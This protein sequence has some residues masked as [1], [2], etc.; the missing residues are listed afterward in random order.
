MTNDALN[1]SGLDRE[2]VLEVARVTEA[3]ALAAARFRGLGNERAADEA[4]VE[5]MHRELARLAIVGQVVLGE[6]SEDEAEKLYI[7]EAIGAGGGP[8]VDIAADPLEGSTLCAKG[9][10]NALSVIAVAERGRLLRVPSMYMSKV[11][12]GPGYP[13]GLVDLDATPA[14]NLARL[15]EAK[16]VAVGELTAC[17]LDR[18]RN[19]ELIRQVREAGAAI[20]LIPD[21]DI[22]GVI[23]TTEPDETGIDI[24]LGIG[25]APE[26]VL[27]AAALSCIGGQIQGRLAPISE[28]DRRRARR[29]GID[30]IDRKYKLADMAS[31][32]VIF[33]ATGVT[34]GSLLDGVWCRNGIAETETLVMRASTGTVR[35]IKTT[36]RKIGQ[37]GPDV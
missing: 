36:G 20:K 12:I 6:G 18:P 11:A 5:A 21:G 17:I 10:S 9:L 33:S 23:W 26:G 13:D 7:G 2:L 24:Y 1:T 35:R 32:D 14:D 16:G 27:A 4:A 31:G 15:A 34:D 29:I 37:R 28:E 8:E 19:G 30:R 3:A 22:A 25:G